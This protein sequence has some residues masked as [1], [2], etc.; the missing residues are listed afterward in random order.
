MSRIANGLLA[1]WIQTCTHSS[2]RQNMLRRTSVP[3]FVVAF[4]V[5]VIVCAQVLVSQTRSA[6]I[7]RRL[8]VDERA[9]QVVRSTYPPGAV[10]PPGPHAFDVVVVPLT[11]GNME[12]VVGGNRIAWKVGEAFYIGRGVE[13]HLSNR[14]TTSVEF[15]TVRIR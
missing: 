2:Q 14:G 1:C 11:S 6:E 5:S 9:V 13:H 12:A 7:T 4:V 15:I 10:E 8:L 3:Y